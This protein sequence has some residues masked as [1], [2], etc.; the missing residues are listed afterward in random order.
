MASTRNELGSTASDLLRAGVAR[1][2]T[3][4]TDRRLATPIDLAAWDVN[5]TE[6]ARKIN[7]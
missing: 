4:D 5:E 7:S 6:L 2:Y 3:R 1:V